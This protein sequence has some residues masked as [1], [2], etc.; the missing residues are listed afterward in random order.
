MKNV[1]INLLWAAMVMVVTLSLFSCEEPVEFRDHFG[2]DNG[3]PSMISDIKV[4]NLPGKAR[5]TYT[6][7]KSKNL[8]Y[9]KADYIMGNGK[10]GTAQASYYQDSLILSGFSDETEKE[11]SIYT[12]SRG[13]VRSEPIVV[14]VKPL[15]PPYKKVF[16]SLKIID[17]FGGYNLTAQNP[18]QDNLAIMVMFKN[19]QNAFEVNNRRSVFT[20]NAK[21]ESK[22]RGME[23]KNTQMQVYVRDN[24]GNSSDTLDLAVTPIFEQEIPKSNFK[25]FRLPGDAPDW[26]GTQV[27]YAWDGRTGWPW[28]IF[29]H[30]ANGGSNPHMVTIDLGVS[31][32]LSRVYIR[33]YPEGDRWFFLTTM[34][35]FEIWGATNPNLN[36]SL[37]DSWNLIGSYELTKP[38]GLPYGSDSPTDRV[39]AAA[40]FN[41][42]ID[43]N[44]AKVRYIRIRCLENFAGGTALSVNEMGVFGTLE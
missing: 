35:R 7:P 33:P 5:I 29:T 21:I 12:V 24:W 43:L 41:W 3:A 30:Q 37:D 14:T 16:E 22:I 40:G 23:A 8:L 34:K 32:K 26:P 27:A 11:V 2:E 31:A 25:A 1:I 20:R 13:E 15:E 10:P 44:A 18:D 36:G 39:L 19:P 28:T 42:D 17:A 6:L 9:V 38:S 4:E